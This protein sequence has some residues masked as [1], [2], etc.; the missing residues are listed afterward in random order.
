MKIALL[1]DTFPPLR[2][3]GAVQLRDLSRELVRQGHDLTVLLPSSKLLKGWEIE[4]HGGVKV[5][6]LLAPQTKD[7][8]QI[9]RAVNEVIMPFAMCLQ[10]LRCPLRNEKWDAVVWYSPSIF[11]GLFVD[12]LK[13]RSRCKSYLIIRDVFPEWAKDMGLIKPGPIYLFFKLVA[14]YQYS[15]AD[16]I[17]VQTLGNLRYFNDWARQ[18]GHRLEVLPNWLD[19]PVK[20]ECPIKVDKTRLVGRKIF[21]YAGNIGVAQGISIVIAMAERLQH[22]EDVGFLFVGRGSEVGA[23]GE[24]VAKKNI[25]NILIFDEIDPD[26][27]AC[28]YEQCFAGIVALDQ[29]H[30]SHNIPGK[31]LTYIQNGLPVLAV[32]NRGND[33]AE[34]IRRES[35]GE[36]CESHSVDELVDMA[37]RMLISVK[38]DQGI[39]DRCRRLFEREFSV[40][41]IASQ[42]TMAINIKE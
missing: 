35:I 37:C 16:I 38:Y 42:I 29:R 27:I 4:A 13:R 12:V 32:V 19:V 34:M 36:V 21:V 11:H 2:T 25:Q 22:R 1:A 24:T 8:C 39:A 6:R 33:I 3:S 15:I 9:L 26:E 40:A 14:R 30:K 7:V 18:K 23:L 31:F 20:K 17:G 41:K 10:Y 5:L 28:L